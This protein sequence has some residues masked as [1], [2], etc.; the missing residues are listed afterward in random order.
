M[1]SGL[2]IILNQYQYIKAHSGQGYQALV[3]NEEFGEAQIR[4]AVYVRADS[5]IS[6]IAQLRGKS[7]LF[8]GGKQAMMS[9]VV[10]TYLLRQG[11]LQDGDYT[12]RF[13]VSP[14]NAVLGTYLKHVDAGGAGEVVLRLPIVKDKIDTSRLRLLA[15]SEPLAHLPWAVKSSMSADLMGRL[16]HLL[17]TLENYEQGR[18]VLKQ[19]GLTGMNPVQDSLEWRTS[20]R[21]DP[22]GL[23]GSCSFLASGRQRCI[24][25]PCR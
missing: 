10:P 21:I 2:K 1:K 22:H 18:L 15:V 24:A 6:S 3:Q 25:R 5:G 8:G 14:P 9:Y 23:L 19:A 4:G 20:H 16:R 7:I 17:I 12:E 11:G 13:A